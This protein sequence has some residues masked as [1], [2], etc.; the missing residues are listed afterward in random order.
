[1]K[2]KLAY[3][4]HL[5]GRPRLTFTAYSQLNIQT[6]SST[7]M[8]RESIASSYID[9]RVGRTSSHDN[10]RK[11]QRRDS[12]DD[13]PRSITSHP[14]LSV[15]RLGAAPSYSDKRVGRTPS[16]VKE[17]TER[18]R[19]PRDDGRRS[20]AP[21]PPDHAPRSTLS[22]FT[23]LCMQGVNPTAQGSKLN[24]IHPGMIINSAVHEEDY[25]HTRVPDP[26]AMSGISS[27]LQT[28]TTGDRKTLF[29]DITFSRYGPIHTK[30]RYMIVVALFYDHYLAVP[31]YTHGGRGADRRGNWEEYLPVSN[32]PME[33]PKTLVTSSWTAYRALHPKTAAHIA[34]PVARSYDAL[35]THSGELDRRSADRLLDH[36]L[37]HMKDASSAWQRGVAPYPRSKTPELDY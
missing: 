31:C 22:Q 23:F 25:N 21:A 20:A 19:D 5:L 32:H 34:R 33:D 3:F 4:T 28:T 27:N 8:P 14:A 10:P 7:V 37:Q 12:S 29:D 18:Y 15:E 1:M 2:F 13:E 11:R 26:D 35:G 36:F 6:I 16:F 17:R 9:N 30:W 24:N